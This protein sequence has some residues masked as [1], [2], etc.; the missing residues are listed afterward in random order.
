MPYPILMGSS[1]RD[2]ACANA[3]HG[4]AEASSIATSPAN[5]GRIRLRG[6]CLPPENPSSRNAHGVDAGRWS[7]KFAR[8]T[9][10]EA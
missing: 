1:D 2:C 4:R 7:Q 10:L 5:A 6:I 3:E 9:L 8:K